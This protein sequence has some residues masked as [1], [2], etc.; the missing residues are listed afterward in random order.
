M[1][2]TILVARRVVTHDVV[3]VHWI[4][5]SVVGV[6]CGWVALRRVGV[7]AS[8]FVVA[9]VVGIPAW[10]ASH[11]VDL[12]DYD[13]VARIVEEPVET[14]ALRVVFDIDGRRYVSYLYGSSAGRLSRCRFGDVVVVR[15]ERRELS[16]TQRVR[17]ASRHVVGS[18]VVDAVESRCAP[19][20]PLARSANRVR[21]TLGLST[22]SLRPDEAALLA[23]LVIGD[24][25]HQP[26]EM[27]EAF[28]AAG[29]SHLTAVSGQNVAFVLAVCGPL[30]RRIHVRARFGVLVAVVAWFVVVTRCEPSVV[31]AG[32]MAVVAAYGAS[33]GFL[34]S[35]ERALALT[36]GAALVVDPL[37]SASVGFQLSTA[38]TAGLVWIAPRITDRIPGPRWFA[39]SIG[40]TVAAHVAV[41]PVSYLTFQTFNVVGLAAN[42]LAVP[43]AG[44]VM[45]AGLP[46]MGVCGLLVDVGVPMADDLARVALVPLRL[47][48]RWVWWVAVVASRL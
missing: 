25:R 18:L 40:V 1:W 21:D 37:L 30:L 16:A 35:G 31:R 47:A 29:L 23:G 10:S 2:T 12:G 32:I 8:S 41:A 44:F 13:G 26:R 17:L 6:A 20:S 14:G 15:G 24:D 11:G 27:I 33:R 39:E 28:R 38:A 4:V 19:G 34:A 45:L 5:H 43:V 46:V 48:V 22:A 7:V 36:V 42:L 9:L 3:S